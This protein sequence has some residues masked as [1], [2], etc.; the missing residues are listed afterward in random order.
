LV[1]EAGEPRAV[2]APARSALNLP[3][4]TYLPEA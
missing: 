2:P 4:L 3:L 1:E